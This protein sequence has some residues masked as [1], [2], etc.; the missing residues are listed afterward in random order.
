M[1]LFHARAK[2]R[3]AL[4]LPGGGARGFAHAGVLRALEHHGLYPSALVGVS[5]G[6]WVAAGYALNPDWYSVLRGLDTSVYPEAVDAKDESWREKVR[7]LLASQ[8]ALRD[9]FLGWGAG[10]SALQHGM[11]QLDRLTCGKLLEEGRIPVSVVAAELYS[12]SRKVISSGRARDAVYASSAVPG[13]LPPFVEGDE[14]L[15]DGTY[16]DDAPVDVARAYGVDVV[17]AID[18]SQ[19]K[20]GQQI[21]NGFQAMTRAVEICHRSHSQMRLKEADMVIKPYFPIP[22]DVLDFHY[23]RC[24]IAAGNRAVRH[25]LPALRRLLDCD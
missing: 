7:A 18:V 9:M 10:E 24:C 25:A 16:V 21:H 8:K 15:I 17:V 23:K 19:Q 20:M 2:R 12:G 13:L 22:V 1:S 14:L 11:E 6:A 3:F 5:M 4:V